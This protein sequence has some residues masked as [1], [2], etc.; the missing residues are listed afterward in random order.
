M[1]K[2][3]FLDRDGVINKERGDYT[4]RIDDFEVNDGVV[5]GLKKL[6]QSGFLLII[7]S[8]QS[9]IAKGVYGH[10]DVEKINQYIFDFFHKNNIEITEIY[11]CPHHNE[12]GLCL[13]RKPG[14]L[15]LEKA[16]ARYQVDVPNSFLIGDRDRDIDAA[17]SVGVKGIKIQSN[18]SIF[19]FVEK[20][21]DICNHDGNELYQ[22]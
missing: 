12:I 18:S 19:P 13:C 4:W 2:T 16:I 3:A 8:N 11:Y 21:C 14:S 22:L 1:N 7:V 20:L 6:Q 5:E 15:M 17:E 10:E 9:G